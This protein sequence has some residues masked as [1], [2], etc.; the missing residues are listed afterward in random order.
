VKAYKGYPFTQKRMSFTNGTAMYGMEQNTP[1]SVWNEI[2]F[3]D[4]GVG[5]T[6]YSESHDGAVVE[7]EAWFAFDEIQDE[8]P[9]EIASLRLT[10]HTRNALET[11]PDI[12]SEMV[13]EPEPESW[14]TDGVQFAKGDVVIDDGAPNWSQDNRLVVK[15]VTDRTANEYQ[16]DE[17]E[18]NTVADANPSYPEDDLVVEAIY[19]DDWEQDDELNTYAFPISRLKPTENSMNH[20]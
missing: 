3:T 5:V 20:E 14:V 12:E 15:E 2:R 8:K 7:D 11:E 4:E 13:S 1:F 6:L 16:Y 19:F 18:I 10:E 9:Q 17:R